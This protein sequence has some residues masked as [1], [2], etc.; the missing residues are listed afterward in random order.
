[1]Q[2]AD[3]LR[4][5]VSK[6]SLLACKD[7]FSGLEKSMDSELASMV[8]SLLKVSIFSFYFVNMRNY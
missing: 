3:N 8:P 7:M 4:S 6:N 1:M 5:A 2:Q